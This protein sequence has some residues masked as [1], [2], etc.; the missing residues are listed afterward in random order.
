V[1]RKLAYVIVAI[2]ILGVGALYA[3]GYQ[4]YQSRLR[5]SGDLVRTPGPEWSALYFKGPSGVTLAE[6]N[7][8]TARMGGNATRQEVSFGFQ[9]WHAKG[10]NINQVNM[11]I[12][13]GPSPADVWVNGFDYYSGAYPPID[14][15]NANF[16]GGPAGVSGA[17]LTLSGFPSSN[18]TTEY[19]VG[20]AYGNAELPA[21]IG[22]T[23][24]LVQMVLTSGSGIPFAG[25]L[26]SGQ[27][28]F[29]LVYAAQ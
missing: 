1:G 29:N 11:T 13:I 25:D 23:S 22:S 2:V 17:V 8:S 28:G 14:F 7:F 4:A 6:L 18:P 21:A 27:F 16:S 5:I 26:Y 15:E 19:G 10:F 12:S 20:L 24:V 3:S 9:L